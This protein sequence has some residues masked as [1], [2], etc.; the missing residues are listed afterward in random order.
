MKKFIMKLRMK[1]ASYKNL[2]ILKRIANLGVDARLAMT[3]DEQTLLKTLV[4]KLEASQLITRNGKV[5]YIAP[6]LEH[7]TLWDM[8]ETRRAE[9]S[10]ARIH[11]WTSGAYSPDTITDCIRLDKFI[12]E[13]LKNADELETIIFN[14]P[15]G[16]ESEAA[17]K[18]P[19]KE[20]KTLLGLVQVTAELFQCSF[21]EAKK[22][23]YSDAILAMAK[24]ME[25]V[26]K[27]KQRTKNMK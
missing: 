21:D 3:H 7:V 18:D 2:E 4:D 11:A 24:R 22:V 5:K 17:E 27:E 8:L 13:Q 6:D 15:R 19:I 25:E 16:A 26:E 9:D 14:R 23:N 1:Y 20:A 12:L 10:V